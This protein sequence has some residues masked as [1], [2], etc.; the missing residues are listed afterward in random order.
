[1]NNSPIH[2]VN[3]FRGY[4]PVIID[5]ETGGFNAKTDALLE[6][7]ATTITMMP[8]GTLEPDQTYHYHIIPFKNANLE[9]SALEF[10]GIDPFHPF[11]MAMEEEKALTDLFGHIRKALKA[12]GCKRA[13]LVGHNPWFDLSF[14]HAAITR[15]HIKHDPFHRFTTFDTAALSAL[16]YGETV[17]AKAVAAAGLPFDTD[18]A[19]SALYDAHITAELFC[20]IVNSVPFFAK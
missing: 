17:L 5:V 8:D 16:L 14:I 12:S 19:H 6:L 11:R 4:L 1:M 9:P 13:V 2:I 7:A 3:R 15:H 20:K 18:K 10:N